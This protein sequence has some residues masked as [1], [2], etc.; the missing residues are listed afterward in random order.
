MKKTILALCLCTLG[1]LA[2]EPR[3]FFVNSGEWQGDYVLNTDNSV[4]APNKS[5]FTVESTDEAL[6]IKLEYEDANAKRLKALPAKQDG[7]WPGF[8]CIELFLDPDSLGAN[9]IQLAIGANGQRFDSRGGIP[10]WTADVTVNDNSWTTVITLP[11]STEGLHA[12]KHG[13]IWGFN[14][15]RDYHDDS[16]TMYYSSWAHVGISF[17]KPNRFGH[18]VFASK[19]EITQ[20]RK[21][22][23]EDALEDIE[24]KIKG[25]GLFDKFKNQLELIRQTRSLDDIRNLADEAEM[26][27]ALKA[28][29]K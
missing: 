26:L 11:Y 28:L 20:I 18:L 4:L 27:I 19:E 22:F 8:D 5:K 1:L 9:F 16:T 29:D 21:D 10:A 6:V 3:E 15:C 14:V 12:P 7:M 17:H 13:E 25:A 2:D 24:T 23:I